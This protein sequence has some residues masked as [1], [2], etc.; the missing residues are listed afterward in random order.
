MF[1]VDNSVFNLSNIIAF[2]LG[3]VTGFA[4]LIAIFAIIIA[5]DKKK[6]KKETGP[7]IE[8]FNEEQVKNLITNKQ[9][10]FIKL[11]EE[12]EQEYVKT[13]LT[14]TLELLHEISSYYFPNSD[15]PEYELTI[16][17]AAE[18]IHYVVDQVIK[19]MDRPIL[20]KLENVKIS[21]IAKTIDSSR[22]VAKSKAM[23]VAKES[24]G[25]V[26][27]FRTILNTLN[28]VMWF[29]KIVLNGTINIA[30]KKLCKA[31]L[32]IAGR[33]FDKVYSKSLFNKDVN[34][35][36]IAL[37]EKQDVE[38]IFKDDKE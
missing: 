29:R 6:S 5:S 37:K 19:Q 38:E 2:L 20:R 24:S 7:T 34:D 33:E 4:L 16:S 31:E 12:D 35:E 36:E 11:V 9:N 17:E 30:L 32:S 18:L 27:A 26:G 22:K 25:A 28:P 1:F 8:K 21:T 3:I 13:C 23:K 15:Y 10:D 14:L